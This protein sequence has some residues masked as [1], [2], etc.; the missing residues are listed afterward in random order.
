L[1]SPAAR[2]S[3][4]IMSL[5][6]SIS[7]RD[8]TDHAIGG[9]GTEAGQKKSGAAMKPHR[10]RGPRQVGATSGRKQDTGQSRLRD[11]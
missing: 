6:M 3:V 2:A 11:G 5:S 10:P 4:A 8:R 9:A 7:G 1:S